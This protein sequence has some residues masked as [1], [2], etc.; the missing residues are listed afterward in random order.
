M[1]CKSSRPGP[2]ICGLL[3]QRILETVESPAN[4]FE[5]RG[6]RRGKPVDALIGI[7]AGNAPPPKD[8]EV[9]NWIAA[10]RMKKHGR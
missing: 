4:A 7:G 9:R 2:P 3:A 1:S 6:T 8:E 10:H 5:K